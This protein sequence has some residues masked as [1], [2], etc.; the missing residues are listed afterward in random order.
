LTATTDELT[1]LTS[2]RLATVGI[3]GVAAVCII[4]VHLA[5]NGVLGF[6]I[7]ELY[8]M[9]SG[10]HP[11]FGYV[12]YPPIVPMLA[13][14]ETSLLGVTPWALRVLP[15]LVGA[16]NVMLC[17]AYVRKL[18]GSLR[19]QALGLL[20]GL[21]MPLLLGTWLFQTVVFDQLAWM[22]SL[23]W[24]LSLVIDRKPRYWILLGLTLGVGLEVKFL[25]LAL[26]AGFVLAV[27]LTPA[28]RQDLRTRYPWIAGALMLVIWLPNIVWQIANGLP[29]LTYVLNHQGD[30]QSGGGVANFVV[31]F[32][33]LLLLLT[34]LWIAGFISLFRTLRLRPVAIACA[35]PLVVYLFVG[36]FYYPAP[37]IA[38]VMAAGLLA[39][40]RV[41]RPRLRWGLVIAV[42]VAGL[43]DAVVVAKEALPTTPASR[44]HATGLDTAN[45]DLA[46]TVGWVA[47]TQQL[48]RIYGALS[49]SERATTVIVSSDYGVTGALD[50]FGNRKL[51]PASYSP[52]LSDWYLL[53]Q[54]VAATDVLMVG[55]TPSDVDWMCTSARIVAHLTTPYNVVAPEQ[56][57]PVTFCNLKAPLPE[58]WGQ[59]KDFS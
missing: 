2:R 54:H 12:D 44:L 22:L 49:A 34:P 59:L 37:T 48:T 57:A 17:G 32:L 10:R 1:P 42:I 38:I 50:I 31:L 11:A 3:Y 39:L 52:Q 40:S 33:V 5:T 14:L 56:D 6:H 28:L 30:I 21:T 29:T 53:P 41:Q 26:I 46:S 4:A 45:A 24:F 35:V 16:V 27:L 58:V 15:A 8:Y 18:G 13:R 9:D 51:L 23:Y 47:V 19:L 7:D 55:Y 36:K 25:I 43:L 20:V